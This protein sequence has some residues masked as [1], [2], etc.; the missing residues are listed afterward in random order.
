[1]RGE[2]LPVPHRRGRSGGRALGEESSAR[3]GGTA[4]PSIVFPRP[5]SSTLA[6]FSARVP[7]RSVIARS[8][9][10]SLKIPSLAS[11]SG[12]SGGLMPPEL[13]H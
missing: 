12:P 4:R 1:M 6:H 10:D 2:K 3:P 13:A 9:C 7:L 8:H 11:A 5:L